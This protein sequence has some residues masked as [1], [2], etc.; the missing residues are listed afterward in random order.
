M[1]TRIIT[2]LLAVPLLVFLLLCN[3]IYII[4]AAVAILSVMGLYEFYDATGL[5]KNKPVCVLGYTGAIVTILLKG[6]FSKYF[7]IAF[8]VWFLILF[9]ILLK[10][11]KTVK[12]K[13]VALALFSLAYIPYLFSHIILIYRF[14][15]GRFL[16]WFAIVGAFITD[17]F[18][19][20]TGVFLGNHKLCPEVSPKKTIEGA[21]GGIL[22][23]AII[24]FLMG[25]INNLCFNGNFNLVILSVIGVVAA[26]ISMMGDLSASIIKR[27]YNIKDYGSLLPGHGGILDRCDS[28]IFVAPLIYYVFKFLSF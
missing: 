12:L 13:D 16:I 18:A 11:H 5:T 25:Y 27:E 6:F 21:I 17:T 26:I 14:E 7:Y 22:G 8:P 20:F 9:I 1:K 24:F 15:N 2:A 10:Y 4:A 28:L 19:Y 23:T 3:N